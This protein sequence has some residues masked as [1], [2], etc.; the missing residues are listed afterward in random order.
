MQNKWG[1]DVTKHN[2]RNKDDEIVSLKFILFDIR[3][4]PCISS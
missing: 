4:E 3:F 1:Y 2:C